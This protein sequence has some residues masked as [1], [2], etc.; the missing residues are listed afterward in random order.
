[1]PNNTN[2]TVNT[3]AF[4]TP[5][6]ITFSAGGGSGVMKLYKAESPSIT[7]SDGSISNGSGLAVTVAPAV[8]NY[9]TLGAPSPSAVAGHQSSVSVA[10]FD[11][12]GNATP[13]GLTG[14]T[15]TA[16]NIDGSTI[17]CPP[18]A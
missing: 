13:T 8:V 9:F 5:T 2:P 6:A 3:V 4:G 1:S 11:L 10:A 15:L 16:T 7:V 12:Y 17:G 14:A 18:P